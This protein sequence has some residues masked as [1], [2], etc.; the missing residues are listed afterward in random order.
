LRDITPAKSRIGPFFP[1]DAGDLPGTAVSGRGG[2][3]GAAGKTKQAEMAK[4]TRPGGAR[5][6]YDVRIPQEDDEIGWS[7]PVWVE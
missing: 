6:A 7:S 5:S 3:A 4:H 2:E 1:C